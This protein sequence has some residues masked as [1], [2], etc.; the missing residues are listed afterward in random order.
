MTEI[1][2]V[3]PFNRDRLADE[4]LAAGRDANGIAASVY[5][6]NAN[7][8]GTA[9]SGSVRFGDPISAATVQTIIAAHSPT[10]TVSDKLSRFGSKAQ[11]AAVLKASTQWASLTSAQ[12]QKVQAVIDNAAAAIIQ[13]IT[14]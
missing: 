11:A 12:Q 7:D 8:N 5:A 14:S 2:L 4:L 1:A 9:T 6:A 10:P 3:S 13:A